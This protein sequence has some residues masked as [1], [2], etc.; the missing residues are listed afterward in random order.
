MFDI[1]PSQRCFGVG[2]RKKEECARY[3]DLA[4]EREYVAECLCIPSFQYFPRHLEV[5]DE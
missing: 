3:T 1:D 5:V 2:C 4:R